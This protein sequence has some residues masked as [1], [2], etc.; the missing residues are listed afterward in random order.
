MRLVLGYPSPEDHR[1]G[2]KNYGQEPELEDRK[3]WLRSQRISVS[4]SA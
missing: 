2:L 3:K 4:E 1:I